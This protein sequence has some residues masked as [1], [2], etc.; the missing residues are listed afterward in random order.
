MVSVFDI[1]ASVADPELPVVTIADLGILREAHAEGDTAKVTITPTYSGCPAMDT[2]KS[3]IA[4]ALQSSGYLTVDIETV[5]APAWTTDWISEEGRRKLAES[6]IAPPVEEATHRRLPLLGPPAPE[7][8]QCRSARVSEL[9]RFGS[10]VCMS[11]WRC[12]DCREPFQH[13]KRH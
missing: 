3:D 12:E 13:V 9:S 11:L 10:T 5:Y 7:C 1:A 2:I 6:G 8:P 4:R